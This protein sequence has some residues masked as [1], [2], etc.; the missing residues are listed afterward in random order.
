MFRH[1]LSAFFIRAISRKDNE[2]LRGVS[3]IQIEVTNNCNLS[4]R[5]CWRFLRDKII[6]VKNFTFSSFKRVLNNLGSLFSIRELNTQGLGEPFMC[7]DILDI[8][9]HAKSKRLSVWLVTN[10]T[11]LD[12]YMAERVVGIGVDK[13]RFSVDSADSDMYS[14][15]K[16]GSSMAVLSRNISLINSFKDRLDMVNPKLSFNSV[17]L[18][19]AFEGFEG[20]IRMAGELRVKE[21]TLIPLVLFSRGL[22]VEKEQVDFYNDGFKERFKTLQGAASRAG[23]EF[24]LG[25]SLESREVKFCHSGFYIDV[26]GFIHPCCN[27][28]LHNFGNVHS[29][30]AHDIAVKYLDFRRWLDSKRLSCKE[31]NKILDKRC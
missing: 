31:C 26:E 3:K 11:L 24:N 4:C 9:A 7:P 1:G 19:G 23:I 16:S 14:A 13:L 30:D 15:I 10:G 28:S 12:E 20:I 29:V 25:V 21:I 17:V 8:L 5:I 22:A 18:R 27:I 2:I 6:P